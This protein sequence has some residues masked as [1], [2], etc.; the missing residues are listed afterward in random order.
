MLGVLAVQ[1]ATVTALDWPQ[2]RGPRRD[3]YSAE[4]GLLQ[5]WPDGGPPLAWKKTGL[6][7]GYSGVAVANGK[8]VTMGEDKEASRVH[9]LNEADGKTIWSVVVGQ[10]GAPGWGGFAGPRATPTLD[11]DRVYA[12]NHYGELVCLSVADGKEI[13][14][15]SLVK[16]LGG[17][18]PEWGYA[19]SPMVDGDKVVVT[20][21]QKQGCL[22]ALDKMT[23][24]VLW[25]TK[26]FTDG[27]QYSS[28]IVAE[29]DGVRQYIQ[30]TDA[31]VCG[32][33]E[34]GKVLWKA[35]RKGNVAV[36]PTPIYADHHVFVT[37]GY[38]VGCNLFK[39]TKTGNSFKAE[40]VYA[41]KDLDNH[42]GGVVLL[43]GNIYGYSD[44]NG[45]VCMEMKTGKVL[46]SQKDK[47]HKGSVC[48]AEGLLYTR[49]EDEKGN[50]TMVLLEA[51]SKGY[52]EK[53]HFDQPDRSKMSSWPHP[54]IVNGKLYLR[55]QDVLL[56]YDVRR[57]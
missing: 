20:P 54:V 19:E 42:H 22:A 16:D 18:V 5:S 52:V 38:E 53:G 24:R 49:M 40:E 8:I 6:G 7:N 57:K 1:T 35:K 41:N 28:I 2:W 45:W 34:D 29:I 12:L 10:A 14:K 23:G 56:T 51:S 48:G 32:V 15:K 30:L 3:G 26:D 4:T 13:W 37:S 55:D 44:H 47:Q 50:G 31:S 25:Q 11:G 39:V 33:A 43:D 21:G 46:W 27:A 36:I 9:L 17:K